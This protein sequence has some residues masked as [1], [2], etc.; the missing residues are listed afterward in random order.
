MFR[1]ISIAF[2]ISFFCFSV[3]TFNVVDRTIGILDKQRVGEHYHYDYLMLAI[4]ASLFMI[5]ASYAMLRLLNA[6]NRWVLFFFSTLGITSSIVV[7]V[8]MDDKFLLATCLFI[9]PQI[10]IVL[11]RSRRAEDWPMPD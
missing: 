10:P 11:G 3:I 1:F 9:I 7:E 8:C 5:M 2:R 6:R 4:F